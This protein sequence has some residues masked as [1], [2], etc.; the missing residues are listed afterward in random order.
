MSERGSCQS[1][2]IQ[3]LWKPITTASVVKFE[4]VKVFTFVHENLEKHRVWPP[5]VICSTS[6]THNGGQ[7]ANEELFICSSEAEP[8][9]PAEFSWAQVSSP[10]VISFYTSPRGS[11]KKMSLI[12]IKWE[13]KL[14]L[15]VRGRLSRGQLDCLSLHLNKQQQQHNNTNL[16]TYEAERS[17]C[18]SVYKAIR[19]DLITDVFTSVWW[20]LLEEIS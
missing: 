15:V 17:A 2:I 10:S 5:P 3:C 4:F 12:R 6:Q 14:L 9:A 16:F 1:F 8:A 20:L 11:L 18:L 19:W 13:P 7:H